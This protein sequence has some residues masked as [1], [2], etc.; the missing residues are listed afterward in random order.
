[1]N[2][3][4]IQEVQPN[5]KINSVGDTAIFLNLFHHETVEELLESYTDFTDFDII[6]EL[7]DELNLN[8]TAVVETT[9]TPGTL[10][11]GYIHGG[12]LA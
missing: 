6:A 8:I 1:M 2:V 9:N 7:V 10:I 12:A 11:H 5:V 4:D 3:I